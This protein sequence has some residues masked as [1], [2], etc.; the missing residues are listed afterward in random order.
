MTRKDY[1]V[2]AAAIARGIAEAD[3]IDA[4]GGLSAD[5]YLAGMRYGLATAASLIGN[6]LTDDNPRF[7]KARFM[8]A[9]I[10]AGSAAR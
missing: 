5:G 9:S 7:D 6:A 10:D 2:I 8:A 1:Q 3:A 4:L